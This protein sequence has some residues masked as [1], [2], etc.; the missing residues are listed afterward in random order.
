ML[1]FLR[2]LGNILFLAL[3]HSFTAAFQNEFPWVIAV[4]SH[5]C[6]AAQL[7]YLPCRGVSLRYL[8]SINLDIVLLHRRISV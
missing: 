5:T 7:L 3:Q 4:N 6:S 1:R 8:E 2:H